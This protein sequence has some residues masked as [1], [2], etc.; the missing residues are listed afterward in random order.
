MGSDMILA[1]ESGG[2]GA[3]NV[4]LLLAIPLVFY[5]LLIR[6][7]SKRRKEQMQMQ[8]D[9]Q[10]GARVLTTS[11]MRATVVDIDDD[12]LVL[13][14]ADGVEVRFVKQAVMQ[15]LKDDEP[16]EIDDELDEDDDDEQD[17]DAVD[18]SKD[19]AEVDLSKDGDTRVEDTA[20]DEDGE[21]ASEPK[22]KTK[23]KAADKPSA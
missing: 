15:V 21:P 5:F 19:G 12:G 2:S 16:D 11:G 8:N 10:P 17:D 7:Q 6:P 20:A 1:A 18:L 23:V 22:G 13:E 4:L 3:F 14:I 9:I